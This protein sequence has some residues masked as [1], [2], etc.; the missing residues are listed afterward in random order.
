[1]GAGLLSAL[2][3]SNQIADIETN[4][5]AA[6]SAASFALGVLTEKGRSRETD[7]DMKTRD[8]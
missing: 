7:K 3:G 6:V 4:L 2:T 5:L 8:G 1:L